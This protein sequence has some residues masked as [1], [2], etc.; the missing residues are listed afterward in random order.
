MSKT[1][2]ITTNL[3]VVDLGKID[4]LVEQG[5]YSNRTDFVKTAV[6]N[7][8]ARHSDEIQNTIT[9]KNFAVGI[10]HISKNYLESCLLKN[11]KVELKV[12][13]KLILDDKITPELAVNAIKSIQILGSI[14]AT[15]EVAGAL[16][17][18][19]SKML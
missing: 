10:Q 12:I 9:K 17:E 8:L 15:P 6:R 4:L 2:K 11:Q 5:H 7:Q 3:G 14:S 1:E 18:R 13:G 19:I 16:E